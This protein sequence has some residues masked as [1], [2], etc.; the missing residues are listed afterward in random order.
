MKLYEHPLGHFKVSMLVEK[1]VF[2]IYA[3]GI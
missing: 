3:G 1:E 2:F